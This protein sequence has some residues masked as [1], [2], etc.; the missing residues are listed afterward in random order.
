[1]WGS[2]S[3]KSKI[4]NIIMFLATCFCC[5]TAVFAASNNDKSIVPEDLISSGAILNNGNLNP[6]NFNIVIGGLIV[7]MLILIG[8]SLFATKK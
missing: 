4:K 6:N 1:M 2:G 5:P 8:T 7:V 3:V